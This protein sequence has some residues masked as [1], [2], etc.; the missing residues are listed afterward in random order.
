MHFARRCKHVIGV[1][2]CHAR[3]ALAQQNA[4]VYGVEDRLDL[5]CAD[6]FDLR[7]ELKVGPSLGAATKKLFLAP[8]HVI[9][10]GTCASSAG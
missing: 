8:N 6:F 7:D 10:E 5:L 3:L 2:N 4:M 1:D 9:Q